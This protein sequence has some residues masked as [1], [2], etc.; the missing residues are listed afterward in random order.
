MTHR[1]TGGRKFHVYRGPP[2][3]LFAMSAVLVATLLGFA[4]M[5]QSGPEGRGRTA[6]PCPQMT[7]HNIVT[8]GENGACV[9]VPQAV[10]LTRD[11]SLHH[12]VYVASGV[13]CT[14]SA[15]TVNTVEWIAITND[16]EFQACRTVIREAADT[17]GI[18]CND[19]FIPAPVRER[20]LAYPGS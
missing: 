17:L 11:D 7:V 9:D 19:R 3:M 6:C 16:G 8:T 20:T 5:A 14:V 13:L 1:N 15:P 2:G 4:P 18:P 10:V 12:R